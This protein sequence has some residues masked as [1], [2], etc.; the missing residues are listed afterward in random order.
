MFWIFVIVSLFIVVR[1]FFLKFEFENVKLLFKSIC[2]MFGFIRE[3][4]LFCLGRLLVFNI[5]LLNDKWREKELKIVLEFIDKYYI[6]FWYGGKNFF[7]YKI[8][9]NFKVYN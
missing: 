7:K 1:M 5:C 3:R 9:F 8:L 2:L 4:S 6:L